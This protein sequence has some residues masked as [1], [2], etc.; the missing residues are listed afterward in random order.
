MSKAGLP[1]YYNDMKN[2]THRVTYMPGLR[3][4]PN[5]EIQLRISYSTNRSME[6]FITK[7]TARKR[8]NI[9]KY[10]L[11]NPRELKYALENANMVAC[12]WNIRPITKE[13]IELV[14]DIILSEEKAIKIHG[15]EKVN[16]IKGHPL[17]PF[18]SNLIEMKYAEIDEIIKEYHAIR[19][20][21]TLHDTDYETWN[22]KYMD[23]VSEKIAIQHEIIQTLID[24]NDQENIEKITQPA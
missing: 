20:N 18:I 6:G 11:D 5:G 23:K 4:A 12:L 2:N 17:D 24:M 1:N 14:K 16:A 19:Q 22:K 3:I 21:W 7:F 8:A 15:L 13:D 9:F 10:V